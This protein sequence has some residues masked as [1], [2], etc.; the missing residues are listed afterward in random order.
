MFSPNITTY[1]SFLPFVSSSFNAS[2]SIF[3][4]IIKDIN[5]IHKLSISSGGRLQ[6]RQMGIEPSSD[7]LFTFMFS[8]LP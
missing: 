3:L 8:L 2:L 7:T 5:T 4:M 1:T 6:S